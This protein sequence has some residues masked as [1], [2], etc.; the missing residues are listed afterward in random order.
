MNTIK[1]M[2][3]TIKHNIALILALC[4]L[5]VVSSC[6]DEPDSSNYYTFK[7]EMMGQYLEN[8]PQFSE[9]AQIVKKAGMMDLF[10]TYGSYTC[11][12]PT[13]DAID[14]FLTGKGKTS[15]DELSVADCDTLTKTH[16]VNNL[17]TVVDM[18]DGVLT[19]P[20]MNKRYI[21]V[22]HGVDEENNAV[23]FLNRDTHILFEAQDDSV[24]NGV[25]QPVDG[26]M[27][28]SNNML[29]DI[30]KSDSTISIFYKALE[31]THLKDSIY[32]YRDESWD[33][34]QYERYKYESDGNQ[35]TA[36]VPDERKFG[37]TVFVET[38][39]MLDRKYGIKSLN[40]LYLKACEIYDATYPEDMNQPYHSFDSISNPKNPLY[41]YMAYHILDRNVVGW[42][43]LTPLDDITID[44]A[45]M[46]PE[47][48][49]ETL[50]PHTLI[51]VQKVTVMKYLGTASRGERRI[52]RR[53]DDTQ[54]IE[55]TLIDKTP[56]AALN[57]IYFYLDDIIS[58]STQTRDVVANRRIRM[59]MATVFPELMT[60]GIRQN[61]DPTKNDAAYDETGKYGRN[62]YFPDGYLENVKVTGGK[63]IYRRPR[64]FYWSYE[65]DEFNTL[66]EDYDV[67]FKL[68]PIPTSGTYQIRL[69]YAATTHRGIGQ[70]YF[71]GK[72]QGIPLDMRI[73]L[74]NAKV[75]GSM[76]KTSGNMTDDEVVESR[77]ILKNKGYYRGAFGAF[78][79]F[80]AGSKD[81][82]YFYDQERTFRIVLCTVNIDAGED[83]YLRFKNV[84]K[85]EKPELM[86][87]YI[88]LVPKSVYGVTDEGAAED[89]L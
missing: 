24:E 74:N 4:V 77:K 61:G 47:D 57:G 62:Y 73:F 10:N 27:E 14:K 13:N 87:D 78:Y 18:K 17:Y 37:Y 67:T 83:H 79:Y 30:L 8:R 64:N 6:S 19:T 23:V 72:P 51:N 16:L 53:Y 28:S 9:F 1:S 88:E 65:G 3:Y 68:P 7:G 42:N 29:T 20:N 86:L 71:D 43:Y 12:A 32:K 25:M 34:T 38:D 69:G 11:F 15:V 85:G 75:L 5:G 41:R 82:G 81:Y 54:T 84:S 49:Y 66:G 44:I 50:L 35:E 46:N 48:W 2:I 36:T 56:K 55:G 89:D 45:K 70:V 39:E 26:V 58:F 76:W 63:F 40:A 52:N 59:D 31:G 22:S 80:G 60:N 21:E 33:P